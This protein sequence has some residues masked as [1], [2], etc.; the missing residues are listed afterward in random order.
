MK[1]ELPA[2]FA[3]NMSHEL[4][5]CEYVKDWGPRQKAPNIYTEKE[6]RL[7]VGVNGIWEDLSRLVVSFAL[8]SL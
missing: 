7:F 8:L 1:L 4:T 5:G 2:V 3:K 6:I